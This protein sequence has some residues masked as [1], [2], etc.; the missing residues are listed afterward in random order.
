M[1]SIKIEGLFRPVSCMPIDVRD[2]TLLDIIIK[3]ETIAIVLKTL[4]F[5]KKDTNVIIV[6]RNELIGMHS[7]GENTLE[8]YFKVFP[9]ILL[10]VE[11]N[12][13][14]TISAI[15]KLELIGNNQASTDLLGINT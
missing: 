4:D 15:L 1:I 5:F 8:L 9:S 3:G 10:K 14:D 13:I 12:K 6:K 7:Y 11:T 2:K